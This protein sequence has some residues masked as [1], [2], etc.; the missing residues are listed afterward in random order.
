MLKPKET[1]KCRYKQCGKTFKRFSSLQ[2][3]CSLECKTNDKKEKDDKRRP[4]PTTTSHDTT[5][6]NK[7]D[8][9]RGKGLGIGGGRKVQ[10][11][12]K[13]EGERK[14]ATFK[15]RGEKK[16]VFDHLKK[17][18]GCDGMARVPCHQ[19][20]KRSKKKAVRDAELAKIKIRKIVEKGSV[21]ESSG[22]WCESITLS[23]YIPVSLRKDLELV[24]EASFLQSLEDHY[25]YE[26]L[27][28]KE[29]A[30]FANKDKILAFLFENDIKRYNL[31]RKAIEKWQK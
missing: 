21:C 3:H 25:H 9:G 13:V 19:I 22:R 16:E 18:Y 28:G 11:L 30:R 2:A 10:V 12:E 29:I 24:P 7:H 5:K 26:H 31:V 15:T 27:H 4:K 14:M 20:P 6:T 8:H 1:S 17:S 23:H